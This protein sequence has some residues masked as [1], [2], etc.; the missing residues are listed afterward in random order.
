MFVP[1]KQSLA[2]IWFVFKCCVEHRNLHSFPTRRSSDLEAIATT[3]MTPAAT[4]GAC[5]S[6]ESVFEQPAST[7]VAGSGTRQCY[8]YASNAYQTPAMFTTSVT[9]ERIV[10]SL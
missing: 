8:S 9:F 1:V 5:A 7:A 10:K 2:L 6:N 4:V 3:W